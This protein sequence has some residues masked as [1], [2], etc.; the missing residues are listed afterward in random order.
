MAEFFNIGRS[1]E[2]QRSPQECQEHWENRGELSASPEIPVAESKAAVE[3]SRS[4]AGE[5]E[6]EIKT[7]P[8][9]PICVRLDTTC[10]EVPEELSDSEERMLAIRTAPKGLGT[11]WTQ[12][13]TGPVKNKLFLPATG[14]VVFGGDAPFSR[15]NP[16][17]NF[18]GPNGEKQARFFS[19]REQPHA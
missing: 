18:R 6:E 11:Y 14:S 15:G 8:S 9:E 12:R 10:P 3:E 16:R 5:E 19:Q 2:E 1:P 4:S 17:T 7:D 13:T